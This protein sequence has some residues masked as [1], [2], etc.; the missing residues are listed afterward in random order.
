[1]LVNGLEHFL[2]I[3]R[4]ILNMA[5]SWAISLGISVVNNMSEVTYLFLILYWLY[6]IKVSILWIIITKFDQNTS[7]DCQNINI[8]MAEAMSV[9]FTITTSAP[10]TELHVY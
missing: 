4:I 10:N 6:F 3:R 2:A 8:I 9:Y 7:Y 1:M 5:F